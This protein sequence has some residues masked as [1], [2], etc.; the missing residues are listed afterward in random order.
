M[1]RVVDGFVMNKLYGDRTANALTA[2]PALDN[3]H[4]A[5]V[6]TNSI[7]QWGGTIAAAALMSFAGITNTP[8][9][10]PNQAQIWYNAG[11]HDSDATVSRAAWLRR[12]GQQGA[13]TWPLLTVDAG[14]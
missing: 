11:K 12:L 8:G 6:L 7:T 9:V 13:T 14:P 1:D 10:R 4:L 2:L 3:Q 5:E